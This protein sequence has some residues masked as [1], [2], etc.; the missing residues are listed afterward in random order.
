MLTAQ[1]VRVV[2]FILAMLLLGT[3]VGHFRNRAKLE[4][5]DAGPMMEEIQFKHRRP[6]LFP[7]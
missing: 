2:L 5:D 3:V 6:A 7:E 1:E 4:K